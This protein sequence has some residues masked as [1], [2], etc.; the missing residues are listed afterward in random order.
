MHCLT[1]V[2]PPSSDGG[3]TTSSSDAGMSETDSGA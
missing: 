1:E 3:K 2:A